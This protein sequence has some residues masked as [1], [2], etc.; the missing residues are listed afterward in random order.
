M[1]LVPGAELDGP[2]ESVTELRETAAGVG[3]IVLSGALDPMVPVAPG[4]PVAAEPSGLGAVAVP[5]QAKE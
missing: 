5:F 2:P 3:Q 1:A 4:D